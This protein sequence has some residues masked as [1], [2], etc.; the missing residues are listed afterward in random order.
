[1]SIKSE[2]AATLDDG[3]RIT[4]YRLESPGGLR[5]DLLDL[6]ATIEAI[7][8][9]D[10]D[11]N[12]ANVCHGFADA[13]QYAQNAP[14]F[15]A[16]IGRFANRIDRGRFSLDGE[17]FE[18]E[19][20]DVSNGHHLHGGFGG[21]H[22]R[23]WSAT[24]G[25][26][27]VTFEL[28]SSDGDQGYPSSLLTKVT[29][30]LDGDALRIAYEAAN[31]GGRATIVNLT[32]HAYFNLAGG[33]TIKEHVLTLHADAYLPVNETLIPLGEQRPVDE[34]PF[35]FRVAKPIGQDFDAAGGY[36]HCFVLNGDAGTLRPIARVTEPA[37][38]RVMEVE[39]DQPG[40]QFYSGNVLD[41]SPAVGG[42]GQHTAFCLETQGFPDAPN[43]PGFPSARLNA[44]ATFKSETIY[45]FAAR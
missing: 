44:G 8:A 15:G 29:F 3:R 22:S 41:A 37:T 2:I 40:V 10:R 38:G 43:Q 35:D 4:R 27:A 6:G 31:T 18:L 17:N 33:G 24:S 32:N 28:E 39:T 26:N 19:L 9:P 16:T 12:L 23:F 34:T 11:G 36:D 21:F 20:S 7:W 13:R 5:V 25:D 1:M 14:Y 42:H 30:S 45:R